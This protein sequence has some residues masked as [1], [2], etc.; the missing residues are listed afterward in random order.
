LIVTPIIPFYAVGDMALPLSEREL[1][2]AVVAEYLSAIRE[3]R[4]PLAAERSGLR[5][6]RTL[7]AA[8]MSLDPGGIAVPLKKEP[9]L[10]RRRDA[11]RHLVREPVTRA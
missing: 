1:L 7:D 11:T 3:A 9:T 5:V 4:P 10:E 2:R 8:A 6:L